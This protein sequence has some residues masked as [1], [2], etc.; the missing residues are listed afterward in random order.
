MEQKEMF[1]VRHL[2]DF[3]WEKSGT[4]IDGW[5]TYTNAV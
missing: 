3:I 5:R 1:S 4:E 2:L